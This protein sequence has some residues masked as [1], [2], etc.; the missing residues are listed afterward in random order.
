MNLASLIFGERE[1][2][3]DTEMN[4]LETGGEYINKKARS[5]FQAI[6]TLYKENLT[7]VYTPPFPTSLISKGISPLL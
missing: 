6:L 4:I 3:L 1:E 2:R 5:P 7:K